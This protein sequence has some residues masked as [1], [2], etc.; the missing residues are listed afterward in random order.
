MASIAMPKFPAFRPLDIN[1]HTT[2][3]T[4]KTPKQSKPTVMLSTTTLAVLYLLLWDH[5]L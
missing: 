1:Q 3:K 2:L 4:T 5:I